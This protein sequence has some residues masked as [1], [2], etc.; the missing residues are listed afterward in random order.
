M[1]KLLIQLLT[2]YQFYITV[3]FIEMLWNSCRTWRL[4]ASKMLHV[5]TA[6]A[7]A[8]IKNKHFTIN[9]RWGN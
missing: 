6:G 1:Q 4:K 9:A 7:D 5:A 2:R 8:V 3:I